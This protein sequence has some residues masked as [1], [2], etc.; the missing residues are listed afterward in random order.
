MP[1]DPRIDL[2][3]KEEQAATAA[4]LAKRGR[5]PASIMTTGYGASDD[6]AY[7]SRDNA[8]GRNSGG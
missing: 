5:A 2:T 7:H 1:L 6:G 4:Y 8:F 3:K